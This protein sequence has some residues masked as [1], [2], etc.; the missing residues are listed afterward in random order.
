MLVFEDLYFDVID[1]YIL[2]KFWKVIA[3]K[4]K[5]KSDDFWAH[6]NVNTERQKY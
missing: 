2:F 3:I 5:N 4:R 6:F 1:Y